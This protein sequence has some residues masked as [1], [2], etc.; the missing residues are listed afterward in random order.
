MVTCA[1]GLE[2]ASRPLGRAAAFR[3]VRRVA[4]EFGAVFAQPGLGGF[5][6]VRADEAVDDAPE[7]RAVVHFAQVCDLVGGD[8][9]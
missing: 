8:V 4:V 1:R 5:G 9:V 3:F 7:A 6:F 2:I